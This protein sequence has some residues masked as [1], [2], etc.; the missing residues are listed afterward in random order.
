M[1]SEMCIRDRGKAGL[2]RRPRYQ[3]PFPPTSASGLNQ[4][5]RGFGLISPRAIKRASFRNVTHLGRT[6]KTFTERYNEEAKP[7]VW[8][9]TFQSIIDKVECLSTRI[10]GTSH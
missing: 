5:E 2:A 9:A 8:A 6:I 10:C 1:G 7:F 3:L 4:E